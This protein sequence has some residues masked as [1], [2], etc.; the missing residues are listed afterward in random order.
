M[1][2]AA[3]GSARAGAD[4]TD[5]T[6]LICRD[7]CVWIPTYAT[8]YETRTTRASSRC[9]CVFFGTS[10]RRVFRVRRTSRFVFGS[11]G[12]DPYVSSNSSP[13]PISARSTWSSWSSA[14]ASTS[15]R[16]VPDGPSAVARLRA[17][18]SRAVARAPSVPAEAL[19]PVSNLR[20]ACCAFAPP[21]GACAP[22]ARPP[23]RATTPMHART[24]GG[25][26]AI[27]ANCRAALADAIEEWAFGTNLATS[28]PSSFSLFAP[29][30]RRREPGRRGPRFVDSRS[31]NF[32]VP[33]R[34]LFIARDSGP[35][36]WR[37]W[38]RTSTRWMS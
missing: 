33:S 31:F 4:G 1:E 20:I 24:L 11:G 3:G 17:L 36:P 19:S 5:M 37:A 28:K 35:S 18:E 38:T 2:A 14:L 21:P 10:S 8:N 23:A 16:F 34:L 22:P 32:H 13:S 30:R 6:D 15:A 12:R 7:T 29:R 26:H 9:E 25:R 27:A